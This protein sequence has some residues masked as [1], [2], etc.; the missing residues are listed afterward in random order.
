MAQFTTHGKWNS[1]SLAQ[2]QTTTPEVS[3]KLSKYQT[4]TFGYFDMLWYIMMY[5]AQKNGKISHQHLQFIKHTTL[6][7]Q[8]GLKL[9]PET[10]IWL[11][12]DKII[13]SCSNWKLKIDIKYEQSPICCSFSQRK[14]LENGPQKPRE[15]IRLSVAPVVSSVCFNRMKICSILSA[16][17]CIVLCEESN[18]ASQTPSIRRRRRKTSL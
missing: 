9:T 13:C 14:K 15:L 6:N 18:Y 12:H 1:Y 16:L 10:E 4:L 17:Q 2:R 7:F 11:A 5:S 3:L 8:A